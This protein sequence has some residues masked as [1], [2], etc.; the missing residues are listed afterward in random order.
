MEMML[1]LFHNF[2]DN[3]DL[4]F[5]YRFFLE[6]NNDEKSRFHWERGEFYTFENPVTMN[7]LDEEKTS[8]IIFRD[9][10]VSLTVVRSR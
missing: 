8:F 2:R 10:F 7:Q 3:R 5:D 6:A 4:N 9:L 1:N